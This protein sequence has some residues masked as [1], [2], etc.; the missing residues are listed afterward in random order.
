MPAATAA[1][2]TAAAATAAATA[3]AATAP[4]A[5]APAAL[6]PLKPGLGDKTSCRLTMFQH[7]INTWPRP[8]AVSVVG[9]NSIGDFMLSCVCPIE[10]VTLWAD[11]FYFNVASCCHCLFCKLE[12]HTI[13]L[14]TTYLFL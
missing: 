2:A 4:V 11:L 1:A 9:G 12:E 10:K 14:Y 6:Y 13:W 7:L 3:A 8:R 5:A